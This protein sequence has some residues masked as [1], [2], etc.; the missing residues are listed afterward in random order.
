MIDYTYQYKTVLDLRA[1]GS[2]Q[3]DIFISAFNPSDRV[4]KVLRR[5]R[6]E[7]VLVGSPRVRPLP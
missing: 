6:R 5:S 1:V 2:T 3:W 4:L 7:E